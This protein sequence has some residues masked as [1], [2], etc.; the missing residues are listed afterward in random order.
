MTLVV[1]VLWLGSRGLPYDRLTTPEAYFDLRPPQARLAALATPAP[2]CR[3]FPRAS[4]P[5]RFLSLSDI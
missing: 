4:P 5:D 3:A 2:C 1:A